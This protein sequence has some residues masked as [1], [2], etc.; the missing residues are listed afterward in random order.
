MAYAR[1]NERTNNV[2]SVHIGRQVVVSF[3]SGNPPIGSDLCQKSAPAYPRV[4]WL[5]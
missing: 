4:F 3:G 2:R 5:M 1:P